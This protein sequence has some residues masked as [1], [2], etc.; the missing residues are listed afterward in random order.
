MYDFVQ[1]RSQQE[2]PLP[3][4]ISMTPP[5]GNDVMQHLDKK[6]SK[7]S[8]KVFD[9]ITYC[10]SHQIDKQETKQ[11]LLILGRFASRLEIQMNLTKRPA[12]F[13]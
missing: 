1:T 4:F 9:V 8:V 2:H 13:R 12:R 7:P 3:R 6:R 11:L 5:T 10:R